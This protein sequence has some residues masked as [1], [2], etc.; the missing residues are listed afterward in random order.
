VPKRIESIKLEH[1]KGA[2]NETIIDFNSRKP[3]VM[4]FGENGTGKSTIV[5]GIDFVSNS[6]F[7]SLDSRSI[8]GSKA[9][10]IPSLGKSSDSLKATINFSGNIWTG[11]IG[12]G[13]APSS[14]GSGDKPIARILRRSDILKIIDRQPRERYEALKDFVH[15]PIAEKNE[16]SLRES[17][18]IIKANYEEAIRSLEQ[19]D[20]YLKEIWQ[21]EG[22]PDGDYLK[23]AKSKSRADISSLKVLSQCHKELLEKDSFVMSS[24]SAHLDAVTE[25]KTFETRFKEAEKKY[26]A[27]KESIKG[28]EKDIVDVLK[29]SKKFIGKYPD[30]DK[31]PVC[32]KSD[33]AKRLLASIEKRLASLQE[34]IEAK[35]SYDTNKRQ[36]EGKK[37][38]L[39]SKKQDWLKKVQVLA[40]AAKNASLPEIEALGIKWEDY[41]KFLSLTEFEKPDDIFPNVK[42][43]SEKLNSKKE[44]IGKRQADI[45]KEINQHNTIK[46]AFK[47]IVEKSTSAG[48]LNK[49]LEI[50][51]KLHEIMESERKSFVENELKSISGEVDLLYAQ[52]H[53]YEGLGGLKLFLKRG[54]ISSLEF[55]GG[56][57]GKIEVQ[58]QAYYSE[59]HLDTLGVCMFLALS[60]KYAD[61]NTVIVLD[62]V[63]TSVDQVHMTR[64]LEMLHNVASSFNQ[65][66]ITT[67]FRPWRDR[68]K[69]HGAPSSDVDLIELLHWSHPRGIQHTQTKLC[70]EELE[71]YLGDEKYDRQI[72]SSKAGILLEGIIDHIALCYGCRLPRKH[73]PDY[74][75]GE[76]LRSINSRLKNALLIKKVQADGSLSKEAIKTNIE[77]IDA[78]D[79]IRN[80]VGCHFNVSGMSVSDTDVK[81]FGNITVNFAKSL[82][83]SDC[84]EL[85]YRNKTG[86]YLECKC[87]KTQMHPLTMPS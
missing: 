65:M 31:C 9:D 57:Q 66:I 67:H 69:F 32:E 63:I 25:L 49:Q 56:F 87:S 23:W 7:G 37:N 54:A 41:A 35:D 16:S 77:E 86:S 46:T 71:E 42:E 55:T 8:A 45:D 18:R 13:R 76:L 48:R 17:I 61:E 51:N 50:L 72:A 36:Y 24:N 44:L 62:D 52:I 82:V 80:Q 21:A 38:V 47:T 4:I 2:T 64:F 79:W 34:L 15:V 40:T 5:D 33:D 85:P 30:I 43:L 39:I 84:G 3:I 28:F 73:I 11:V 19:A 60:K 68:Y 27:V 22:S 1:F 83:C 75:L 81:G 58:P 14:S 53:P 12:H 26:G 20:R 59:S 6:K 74:T 78:L 10:L 29:E 70:I